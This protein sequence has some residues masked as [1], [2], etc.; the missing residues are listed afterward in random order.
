MKLLVAE[1]SER[2]EDRAKGGIGNDTKNQPASLLLQVKPSPLQ[3]MWL[4][5]M[6]EGQNLHLRT[7]LTVT[8][9]LAMDRASGIRISEVFHGL[10][11]FQQFNSFIRMFFE[12]AQKWQDF[13][14]GIYAHICKTTSYRAY[15]YQESASS[16]E[17]QIQNGGN[18]SLS[19]FSK[20]LQWLFPSFL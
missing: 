1:G 2:V 18:N 16:S 15:H 14:G 6:V 7:L 19:A 8:D 4:F 13:Y 9:Q 17:W 3:N 12:F 20:N 10:F 5:P 11:G